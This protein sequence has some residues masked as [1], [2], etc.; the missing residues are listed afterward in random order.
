MSQDPPPSAGERNYLVLPPSA[1]ARKRKASTTHSL[2]ICNNS[3][4][5]VLIDTTVAEIKEVCVSLVF[6]LCVR[7]KSLILRSQELTALQN[8][9][10][11]KLNW[12]LD[13]NPTLI[14]FTNAR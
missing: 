7:F 10:C 2:L 8:D 14:L 4:Q 3:T 13:T 6:P 5:G 11:S 9:V 12:L 1:C